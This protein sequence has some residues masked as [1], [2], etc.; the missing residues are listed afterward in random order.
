MKKKYLVCNMGCDDSNWFFLN[1]TDEELKLVIKLINA[2]NKSSCSVCQPV[3][4][5]FEYDSNKKTIFDYD[6]ENRLNG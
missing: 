5:I 2:N 1:L 3:L 4:N 6:I